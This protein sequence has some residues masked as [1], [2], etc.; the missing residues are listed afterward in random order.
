MNKTKSSPSH[1]HQQH[2]QQA[3]QW[4]R[5][6][7][8]DRCC[9]FASASSSLLHWFLSVSPSQ[10]SR[11]FHKLSSVCHSL[12]SR[13]R[14]PSGCSL[15]RGL[16]VACS[17]RR[18]RKECSWR[19]YPLS[20]RRLGPFGLPHL[21]RKKKLINWQYFWSYCS[22]LSFA[23]NPYTPYPTISCCQLGPVWSPAPLGGLKPETK[24]E[25]VMFRLAKVWLGK[26]SK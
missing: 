22:F 2:L 19:R 25:L 14:V 9:R 4:S 10:S 17:R 7:A 3:Q 12:G 21:S 20:N 16:L 1:L 6:F 11:S 5:Q 26:N 24:I 18:L 15:Q 8:T 23:R 13:G